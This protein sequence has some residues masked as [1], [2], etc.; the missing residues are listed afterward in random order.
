MRGMAA[1]NVAAT[2]PGRRS[3]AT[4]SSGNS[5]PMFSVPSTATLPHQ[6]PR[7]SVRVIASAIRPAGNALNRPA[8][9]G[10][11]GGSSSVVTT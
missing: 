3:A 2:P 10:C 8:N 1:V 7:G 9:S 6:A 4:N 5:S 11:P